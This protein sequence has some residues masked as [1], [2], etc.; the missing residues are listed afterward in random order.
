MASAWPGR[1]LGGAPKLFVVRTQNLARGRIHEMDLL[2]GKAADRLVAVGI[3]RGIFGY[4]TLDSI[5][6]IWATE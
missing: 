4:E 3:I 6:G 5:A 2:A 1:A